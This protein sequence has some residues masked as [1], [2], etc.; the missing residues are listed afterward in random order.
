MT[1]KNDEGT[2][3]DMTN[4][5]KVVEPKKKMT[6]SE[7]GK[8][9]GQ[10]NAERHDHE[11]YLKLGARGGNACLEKRGPQHYSEIGKKGGSRRWKAKT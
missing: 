6:A 1:E 5:K 3:F 7:A 11:Y 9:G 10:R 4:I 2:G 8:I